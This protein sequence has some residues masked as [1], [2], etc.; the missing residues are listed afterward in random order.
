MSEEERR[1][2]EA[3]ARCGSTSKALVDGTFCGTCRWDL[4]DEVKRRTTVIGL[5]R[6]ADESGVSGEGLVAMG[7]IMPDGGAA[8]QWLND[9]NPNVE[10]SA[11]GWALYPGEEGLEDALEVHGH[12]G[13]TKILM[14]NSGLPEEMGKPL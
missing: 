2:G 5:Y 1:N 14:L 13:R 11:N 10:T 6:V 4:V 7:V 12:G 3:C 9:A 8:I